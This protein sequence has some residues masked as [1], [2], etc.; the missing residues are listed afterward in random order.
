M[1]LFAWSDDFSVKVPSID[2]Q[3]KKLVAMLNELHDGMMGGVAAEH[4]G[5]VLDGLIEYTA[6]HFGH[7]EELFAA[8]GYPQSEEHTAE[9]KALV[10]QVLDF[11]EKF[12]AKEVTLSMELMIF[13]K[14]WLM[15]HILESDKAYSGY[16][17][18]R[19][20]Q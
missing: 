8:H 5:S 11:K 9:H 12:D 7:E 16:L 1:A 4:L 17:V 10:A 13:L 6:Y 3:H 19:Q 20:V 15:D 18:E 2:V 14:D